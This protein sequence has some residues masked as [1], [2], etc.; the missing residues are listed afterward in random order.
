MIKQLN[1]GDDLKIGEYLLSKLDTIGKEK[2]YTKDNIDFKVGLQTI[3]NSLANGYNFA[4]FEETNIKGMVLSSIVNKRFMSD[5]LLQ[6]TE[7]ISDDSNIGF[8]LLL[9]LCKISKQNK[10]PFAIN[11]DKDVELRFMNKLGFHYV[12]EKKGLNG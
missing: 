6:V 2:G 1:I 3:R 7:F 4:Y 12:Y 11:F 8:K 5:K 10:I 9:R